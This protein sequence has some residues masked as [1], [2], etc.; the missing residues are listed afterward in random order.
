MTLRHQ[1]SLVLLF[2][3]P[4]DLY[5]YCLFMVLDTWLCVTVFRR[6]CYF[7]QSGNPGHEQIHDFRSITLRRQVSLG[8]LFFPS[9]FSIAQ[10]DSIFK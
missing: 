8:L 6:F 4:V 2:G 9:Y 1:V 3:Q 5:Q 10:N 7:R